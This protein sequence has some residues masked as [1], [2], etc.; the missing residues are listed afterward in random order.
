MSFGDHLDELRGRLIRAILG[1]ALATG[2]AFIFGQEILGYLFR[3]LLTVQVANGLQPN[4][5]A[6]S[7]AAAF[8]AY[9]KIGFLSGMILAMPWVL[10]QIWMFVA[11]GLYPHE[12]RF[13]RLLIGPS[14]GLFLLGVLFLYVIVLPIV[15]NFFISFN[16]RFDLP[17][18]T[19]KAFEQLLLPDR[20]EPPPTVEPVE[21]LNVAVL[22]ADPIDPRDGDLWVNA[23]TRRLLLKRP[24]E[25]W[26]IPW[27]IGPT[28]SAVR[29]Q[30][31]IDYY[32]SFVLLLALAFGLAFET[33]MVV[34]FLAWT[35]LMTTE[36]MA[37]GRRYVLLGAVILAAVL[38]PP[39]VISQCLLAG[40]M[41][42]LFELGLLAGRVV[43]RRSKRLNDED[44]GTSG[45]QNVQERV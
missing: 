43:E 41:Y 27:E 23:T 15:L 45:S 13:T 44:A 21:L 37:R 7:P 16:Q 25:I 19:P 28:A 42:L 11:S 31:A 38:T 2:I 32:I 10:Y 34:F 35:G 9:L 12:R 24:S 14:I 26:S 36:T 33:P 20:E 40:P 1:V 30:F 17:D 29:S 8:N 6:L 22:N 39:D 4:L 3:P 5:Q 18:L